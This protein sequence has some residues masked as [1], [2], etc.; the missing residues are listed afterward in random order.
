MADTARTPSHPHPPRPRSPNRS[1]SSPGTDT[2]QH[3][4]PAPCSAGPTTL[5]ATASSTDVGCVSKTRCHVLQTRTAAWRVSKSGAA[6]RMLARTSLGMSTSRM[7]MPGAAETGVRNAEDM[8]GGKG[9]AGTAIDALLISW[10][11]AGLG[12]SVDPAPYPRHNSK[13]CGA[14]LS[15]HDDMVSRLPQPIFEIPS[16]KMSVTVSAYNQTTLHAAVL[17][18]LLRPPSVHGISLPSLGLDLGKTGISSARTV[19]GTSADSRKLLSNAMLYLAGPAPSPDGN[20]HV[21]I[22]SDEEDDSPIVS[23]IF[24]RTEPFFPRA[25]N[26]VGSGG[27]FTSTTHNDLRVAANT[28]L[29][30]WETDFDKILFD[31]CTPLKS[32]ASRQL[33][34]AVYEGEAAKRQWQDT[35]VATHVQYQQ[36]EVTLDHIPQTKIVL[37]PHTQECSRYFETTFDRDL[38]NATQQELRLRYQYHA[39]TDIQ[40][41]R[42]RIQKLLKGALANKKTSLR[43]SDGPSSGRTS[44]LAASQQRRRVRYAEFFVLNKF[45]APKTEPLRVRPERKANQRKT[46][47]QDSDGPSSSRTSASCRSSTAAGWDVINWV[48]RWAGSYVTTS[49]DRD[50]PPSFKNITVHW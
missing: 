31:E 37:T 46:S 39:P 41:P 12:R 16:S 21:H 45:L 1:A 29:S 8:G 2:A 35:A 14:E 30:R 48:Q 38:P 25:P 34:V 18:A 6:A 17:A 50:T 15:D 27:T 19:H 36:C 42:V 28:A 11:P 24:T 43:D 44:S 20:A 33:S 32:L 10:P 9:G 7:R 26:F 22:Q 13:S 40:I 3:T 23:K 49:R 4:S 47:L 5:R